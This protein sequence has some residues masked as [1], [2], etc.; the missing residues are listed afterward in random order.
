MLDCLLKALGGSI[1]GC[2]S[3]LSDWKASSWSGGHMLWRKEGLRLAGSDCGVVNGCGCV[4]TRIRAPWRMRERVINSWACISFAYVHAL[5]IIERLVLQANN[6]RLWKGDRL[7]EKSGPL[8]VSCV[9]VFIIVVLW[10]CQN[11]DLNDA[12]NSCIDQPRT[13]N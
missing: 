2:N 4:Y 7:Q 3:K 9:Y 8:C 12:S 13:Y 11:A 5:R 6:T 10:T 1:A